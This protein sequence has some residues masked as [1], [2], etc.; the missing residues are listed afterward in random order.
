MLPFDGIFDLFE[1]ILNIQSRWV[2]EVGAL[3][4]SIGVLQLLHLRLRDAFDLEQYVIAQD[5]SIGRLVVFEEFGAVD[6]DSANGLRGTF[7]FEGLD[8]VDDEV[9]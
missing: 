8:P 7:S 2:F 1:Q 9:A 6:E 4:I 5:T 3:A